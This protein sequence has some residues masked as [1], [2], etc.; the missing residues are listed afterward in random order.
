MTAIVD[1]WAHYGGHYEDGWAI[2]VV[3]QVD[4]WAEKWRL[5]CRM[6]RPMVIA[7][8][9]GWDHLWRPPC[10]TAGPIVATTMLD[11]WADAWQ[12]PS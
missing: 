8:V 10:W 2:L 12:P 1:G 6:A 11:G 5:P 7:I 9:D 3:C 4:V